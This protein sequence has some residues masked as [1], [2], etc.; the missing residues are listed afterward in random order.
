MPAV[1]GD[2]IYTVLKQPICAGSDI[3]LR[4]GQSL[5]TKLGV[6]FSSSLNSGIY[7][8]SPVPWL[9]LHPLIATA[10]K[11]ASFLSEF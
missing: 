5:Q 8:H 7:S 6:P 9:C 1:G 4:L 2:S 10:G 3:S 11:T